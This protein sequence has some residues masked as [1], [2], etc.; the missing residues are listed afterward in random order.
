MDVKDKIISFLQVKGPSLP[1]H[2]AKEIGQDTFTAGAHL[3]EM[4]SHKKIVISGLKVGGSPLYYL[5]GQESRLQGFVHNLHEREQEAVALLREAIIIEDTKAIPVV[6]ASFRSLRDFA[7]PLN[8]T[9][10][11]TTKLFWKWY[12]AD[13]A[14]ARSKIEVLLKPIEPRKDMEKRVEQPKVEPQKIPEKKVE[15][16]K[17][18]E[19]AKQQT[20]SEPKPITHDAFLEDILTYFTKEKIKII[21][22]IL[23]RKGKEYDFVVS[24]PSAVGN[25][26]YFIKARNKKNINDGDLAS[27]HIQGQMKK[28][29]TI[30]LSPGQL[31]KKAKEMHTSQLQGISVVNKPWA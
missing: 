28:L 18:E 16:K 11:G 22:Q 3:S 24:M 4:A 8:V 23:V 31:N 19:K 6:R 17:T 25:L 27:L 15:Q 26:T 9:V 5:P 21:E 30:L 10:S 29:P 12:L 13:E 2:I 7:I 20:L 14:A 1:V